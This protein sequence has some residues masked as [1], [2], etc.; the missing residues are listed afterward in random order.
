[1]AAL[2]ADIGAAL[3]SGETLAGALQHC[4]AAMVE[5]LD[6]AFARIWTLN[7]DENVLEMQ[8]SAGIYTHL[9][10]PHGRVKVGEFKIGRIAQSAQPL[11]TNDVQHDANSSDSEWAGREG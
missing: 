9:N 8:A 7:E 10:G 3:V 2:R 11:L 4:A 1:M 6:A 5:H